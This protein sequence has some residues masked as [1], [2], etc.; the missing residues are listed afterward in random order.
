MIEVPP[1]NTLTN[2]SPLTQY[3]FLSLSASYSANKNA[4]YSRFC[5][6][7]AHCDLQTLNFKGLPLHGSIFRYSNLAHVNFS[8]AALN[9]CQ[10]IECYFENNNFSKV[11]HL[12]DHF[13][14]GHTNTIFTDCKFSKINFKKLKLT[15]LNIKNCFMYKC[16]FNNSIFFRDTFGIIISNSILYNISFK[17]ITISGSIS[18]SK[19]ILKDCHLSVKE[20][21]DIYITVKK[22]TLTN[23]TFSKDTRYFTDE[24]STLNGKKTLRCNVCKRY[25][26]PGTDSLC[27]IHPNING[28]SNERYNCCNKKSGDLSVGCKIS[29]HHVS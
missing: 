26:F 28:Y 20:P 9:G 11:E 6:H 10:F 8:K 3:E 13:N 27:Y 24:S 7:I 5:V 17:Q 21:N 29:L 18:I 12:Y 14:S 19:T 25:Y 1:T 22:S 23:V 2:L 15:Q 4:L 16:N